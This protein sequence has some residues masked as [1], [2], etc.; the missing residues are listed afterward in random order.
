MT[1]ESNC[2]SIR[3]KIAF[4]VLRCDST[5]NRNS[6]WRNVFLNQSNLFQSRSCRN[7]ELRRHQVNTRDFF[8]DCMFHLNTRIH[9]NKVRSQFRIHQEFD[10]T[11]ILIFCCR[12]EFHS[13]LVKISS[14]FIWKRPRR[15]HF[16]YFLVSTL[17][18]TISF[19][20]V[21]YIASTITNDLYFNMPR[22]IHKPF[23]KDTAIT[24]RS[25]R[26]GR[27]SLEKGN[28]VFFVTHHAHSL[29]TTTH[30]SF[31][32]DWQSNLFDALQYLVCIRQG[33]ITPWDHGHA[34]SDCSIASRCLIAKGI[35][36]V[37]CRTYKRNAGILTS[38]CKL[39]TL[40]KKSISRMNRIH[41]GLLGNVND[42]MNIEIC[43]NGRGSFLGCEFKRS[44]G[45]PPV[46]RVP[47]F[48]SINCHGSSIQLR[49]RTHDSHGDF[50]SI[51]SHNVCKR[52]N[53]TTKF[54]IWDSSSFFWRSCHLKQHIGSA[55][56]G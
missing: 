22:S 10:S 3:R 31:D 47:V 33:S 48:M 7:L 26:F 45:T 4:G 32:N 12:R 43:R 54:L 20:Q 37:N 16:N 56:Q 55:R 34:R 13:I 21:N 24:K 44:I 46:L 28:E 39:W 15:R 9:F 30:A 27:S 14:K 38:L 35:E 25:K 5:L 8:R 49:R 29:S 19:P 6:T 42:L 40:G 41:I 23:N 2:T 52:R 17:N 1:I 36:I 11:S 53:F 50:S 51:G 18:R